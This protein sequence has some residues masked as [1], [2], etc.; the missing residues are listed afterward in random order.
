MEIDALM[1][2]VKMVWKYSSI[3]V[4]EWYKVYHSN[5][6][7]VSKNVRLEHDLSSGGCGK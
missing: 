1:L 2:M 5:V 4:M 6:L 3:K 7:E